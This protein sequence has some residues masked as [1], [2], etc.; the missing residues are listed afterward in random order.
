MKIL[1]RFCL[2]S[3]RGLMIVGL[4]LSVLTLTNCAGPGFGSA[5]R[6][7]QTSY[8]SAEVKPKV[9]GPWEGYW[10]STES[11]HT[12]K[13]RAIATPAAPTVLVGGAGGRYDFRYHAK[14]AKVLSATYKAP[15]EVRPEPGS[16]DRFS[17][18]AERDIAFLGTYT[19]RGTID[20]DKLEATYEAAGDKGV[21]IM[22]RPE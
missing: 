16:A 21:L 13:L 10:K 19:S 22:Q 9:S 2:P 20:G 8:R 5:Y 4:A 3:P 14:W 11:G 6:K 7:A 15:N 17:L 1:A 18:S 12:G